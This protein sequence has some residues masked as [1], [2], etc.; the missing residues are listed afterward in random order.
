MLDAPLER[1]WRE[2]S[3]LDSPTRLERRY[4]KFRQMGNVGI[5]E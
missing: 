4:Q 2:V 5:A 3:A 1:A